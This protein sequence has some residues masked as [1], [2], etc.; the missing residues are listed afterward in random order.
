L[1]T[2]TEPDLGHFKLLDNYMTKQDE[3]ITNCV[4]CI[5]FIRWLT[6]QNIISENYGTEF[7][8]IVTVR[9]GM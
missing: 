1:E 3:D 4:V 9:T 8:I 5:I 2:D 6:C 7:I